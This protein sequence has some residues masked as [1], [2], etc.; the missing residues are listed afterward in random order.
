MP[1]NFYKLENVRKV[2]YNI[3][4]IDLT[5]GK[6]KADFLVRQMDSLGRFKKYDL[7]SDWAKRNFIT[8]NQLNHLKMLRKMHPALF[9]KFAGQIHLNQKFHPNMTGKFNSG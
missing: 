4:H 2:L 5:S 8:T 6:L 9:A 3:S 1:A 7:F